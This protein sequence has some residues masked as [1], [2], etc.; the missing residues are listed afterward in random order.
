M[1]R[2]LLLVIGTAMLA[3]TLVSASS[4][5]ARRG[6]GFDARGKEVAR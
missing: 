4:A 3:V 2:R 6:S 1:L 5:V